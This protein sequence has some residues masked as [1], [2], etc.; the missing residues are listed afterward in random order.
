MEPS[1]RESALIRVVS[2]PKAVLA[3]ALAA[4][5]W[6]AVLR[7]LALAGFPLFDI[8]RG[9]GTLAFPSGPF[10]AWWSAGLVLH[11][12][13]GALWAIFYAYFFWS[14]LDLKPALQGLVFAAI[15]LVLAAFV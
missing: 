2:F 7:S 4:L 8:V 12:S 13:V 9:L 1:E 5:V 14:E 10:L 6:E 11:A 3:G 15:P